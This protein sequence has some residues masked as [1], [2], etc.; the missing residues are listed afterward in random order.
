MKTTRSNSQADDTTSTGGECCS[1]NHDGTG[2]DEKAIDPV[3]G[4]SVNVA[5]AKHKT[6]CMMAK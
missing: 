3:C 1:H 5:T 2:H 4:M 6:R